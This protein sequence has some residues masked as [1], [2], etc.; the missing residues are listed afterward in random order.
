MKSQR[1]V[2]PKELQGV[3]LDHALSERLAIS[4]ARA[5]ALILQ[6]AVYLNRKRVRIASKELRTGA[7]IE[8]HGAIDAPAPQKAW[9]LSAGQI[10]SEDG[11]W[12]AI[13]K[14]AGVPTQPTLDKARG[15]LFEELKRFLSK[16]DGKPPYVGLHHRLDRDTSGVIVFALKQEANKGLAEAFR[17]HSIT[18]RYWALCASPLSV[19][20]PD[21]FEVDNFLAPR[22]I[23]GKQKRMEAVRSGGDKALTRFK[24]LGR[25]K[26][27]GQSVYW[28]E[29][30][31]QTGRMHQ[32]RAHLSQQ[33]APIL[34]DALY[35]GVFEVGSFRIPRC[36][37][38]AAS[39]TLPHPIRHTESSFEAPLPEDFQRCL[40]HFQNSESSSSGTSGTT[41]VGS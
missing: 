9:E 8:I 21:Q 30:L 7:T 12:I 18:K 23:K 35:G 27:A 25:W 20:L 14:P 3:R 24:V 33:G 16:R 37:L 41:E 2:V 29:C 13:N 5:R 15:N 38:H 1:I 4:R 28:V 34:G 22:V 10:L 39:L 32:I 26:A 40:S 31:P 19:R 11:D 17:S 6:G 36:L